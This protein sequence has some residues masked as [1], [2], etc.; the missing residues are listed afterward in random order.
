MRTTRSALVL[1]GLLL[2]SA[3][4]V[5]AQGWDMPSFFS[6]R[7]GEDIG[8]YII[9]ADGVDDIGIAG[10][11]R[12]EG[13][14]NLGVRAGIVGDDHFALGAE[15]YGPIRGIEAPIL[16]SWVVGLG[17]TFNDVTWLRIPAGVSVGVNVDAG[18]VRILPYVHPRVAFDY[19]S[20]DTP[21]GD[22]SDSELNFDLDLG[23]D[24]DVGRFVLRFGATIG[25]FD[26]IGIGAAYKWGRQ[27]TVR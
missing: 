6:P 24:V 10:I 12:Q 4:S 27:V 21:A 14:L 5:A 8:L 2:G 16:L 3:G 25:D 13:N 20:F 15:F 19:F 7:P 11:W 26:A 23:A 22:E 9:D 1:L 18:S 17:G